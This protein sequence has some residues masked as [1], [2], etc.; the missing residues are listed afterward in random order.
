MVI[1]MSVVDGCQV[2]IIVIM[3]TLI[4]TCSG[5]EDRCFLMWSG[6]GL[7]LGDEFSTFL[8]LR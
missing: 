5:Q 7:V 6:V 2:G 1:I 8:L 4:L 3:Y